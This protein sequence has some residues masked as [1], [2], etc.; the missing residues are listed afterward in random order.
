MSD[1]GAK[2]VSDH[3]EKRGVIHEMEKGMN[4]RIIAVMVYPPFS[5]GLMHMIGA[6]PVTGY[7]SRRRDIDTGSFPAGIQ[8]LSH[9]RLIDDNFPDAF[10][11]GFEE[12]I[13]SRHYR[14]TI[15]HQ[16]GLHAVRIIYKS[17]SGVTAVPQNVPE[18]NLYSSIRRQQL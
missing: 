6:F 12:I 2:C 9:R 3:K 17:I 16:H 7:R 10:M 5:Q 8:W 1:E 13:Q 4:C 18:R 11:Q 14:I 15:S